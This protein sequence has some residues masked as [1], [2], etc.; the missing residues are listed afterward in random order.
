MP[1]A[2]DKKDKDI[3]QKFLEKKHS[4]F[5]TSGN[6]IERVVKKA[7]GSNLIKRERIIAG[8]VNEVYD[9]VTERGQNII[10]RI[11][12]LGRQ[13]FET[14][15][16]VIRLALMAGVP[17]PKVLLIEQVSSGSENPTFCVEEKIEG[18][19]LTAL[20]G[21]LDKDILKSIISESGKILSKIHGVTVDSF[22]HLDGT[23]SFKTWQ[24]Y[25]FSMMERKG[26]IVEVGKRIGIDSGLIDKAFRLLGENKEIFQIEKPKLLHGDFSPKHLLVKDNHIT[27]II[28]FESAKGGDPV[29]DLARVDFFYSDSFPIDWVKAGYG[30]KDLFGENFEMKMKLYRLHLGLGLLDYYDSEKNEAGLIHTKPRF[31]KELENF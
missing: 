7:T 8:E 24:D 9:V 26:R 16:K 1:K 28:D 21:T 14:E 4:A 6:L 29:S 22:G 18:E 20:M 15:E 27:G 25:I 2:E 23:T 19:P 13:N 10:V 5:E 3:Y 31:I 11:S 12:R 17:A 30:S